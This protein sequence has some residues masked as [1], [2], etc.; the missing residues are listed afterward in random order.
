MQQKTHETRGVLCKHIC[1]S[2]F[3]STGHT[4]AHPEIDCKNKTKQTSKN[5]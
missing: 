4:F 3:A 5:E 2:C 1:N